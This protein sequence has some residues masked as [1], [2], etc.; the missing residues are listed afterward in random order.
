MIPIENLVWDEF[1]IEHLV[2]CKGKAVAARA[3]CINCHYD[4]ISCPPSS[5][6][7]WQLLIT[8][9]MG[10][11]VLHMSMPLQILPTPR[12][13]IH[14]SYPFRRSARRRQTLVLAGGLPNSNFLFFRMGF[15]FPPVDLL[16]CHESREIPTENQCKGDSVTLVGTEG[17]KGTSFRPIHRDIRSQNHYNWRLR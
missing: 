15:R 9:L 11:T 16:L 2:T 8:M 3:H 6:V 4:M 5:A 17:G 14:R 12:A 10:V 7:Q 1:L 13:S